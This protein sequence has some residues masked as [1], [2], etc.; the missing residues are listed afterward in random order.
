MAEEIQGVRN[1]GLLVIAVVLGL[2]VVVVYNFQISNIKSAQS[3]NVE[4]L[5]QYT[6][7]KEA[8][9]EIERDDLTAV[10]VPTQ[11][12]EAFGS[13]VR[14]ENKDEIVGKKLRRNVQAGHYVLWGHAGGGLTAAPDDAIDGPN[15]A[16]V[17]VEIEQ[18]GP[19]V[20]LTPDGRVNLVGMFPTGRGGTTKA[21]T[22]IENVRVLSVGGGAPS[23]AEDMP[24]MSNRPQPSYRQI[25]VELRPEV[26]LELQDVLTFAVG[27]VRLQVLNREEQDPNKGGVITDEV[28]SLVGQLSSSAAGGRAS[29]G[30]GR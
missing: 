5:L 14:R 27:P 15:R 19:G 7:A 17:S 11:A 29:P 25:N 16:G 6:V 22:I 2:V 30:R 3:R 24:G 26:D 12:S 9:S 20:L 4:Y 21:Y 18:P 1:M 13:V 8:G 10:P 28:K 23:A